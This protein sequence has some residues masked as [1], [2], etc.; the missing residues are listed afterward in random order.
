MNDEGSET[1]EHSIPLL[2]NPYVFR[3]TVGVLGVST[4][5]FLVF[6]MFL[7][8]FEDLGSTLLLGAGLLGFLLLCYVIACVVLGNGLDA[9]FTVDEEGIS[10]VAGS[11]TRK[12]NRAAVM[13]GVVLGSAV[14]AGAGLIAASG[15]RNT[16]PWKDI[17]GIRFDEGRRIITVRNSWRTV[18]RLYCTEETYKKAGAIIRERIGDRTSN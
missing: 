15:E 12:A 4:G 13:A 5:L 3:D 9:S 1:W 10:Y 7:T 16:Y 6:F 11:K 2:T 17:E 18:L 8:G 14:T